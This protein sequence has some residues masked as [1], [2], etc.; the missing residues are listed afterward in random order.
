[1]ARAFHEL[2]RKANKRFKILEDVGTRKQSMEEHAVQLVIQERWSD[3]NLPMI[4]SATSAHF[5]SNCHWCSA[6]FWGV[7]NQGL[8]PSCTE[9]QMEQ[10]ELNRE[11]GLLNRE[12]Q[13]ATVKAKLETL[14]QL[15]Q[16]G[17]S[18]EKILAA[19]GDGVDI[20]MD[21]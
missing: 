15:Q 19:V 11:L 10:Y 18:P 8:C 6:A 7:G 14:H 4:P 12:V 20:G 13:M 2:E 5:R 17:A 9:R 3:P 21:F 16:D 1:M